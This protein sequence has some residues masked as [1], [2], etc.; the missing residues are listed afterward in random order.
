MKPP[1]ELSQM[2]LDVNSFTFSD[3]RSWRGACPNCGGHRRFVVFTDHEWPLFNGFC[4]ECG[5]KIKAWEKVKMQYDPQKAAALQAERAREEAERAEYRKVKL[6]EF[7]TA[8]LWA[9]L[10]DRMQ[11][12]HVLWWESQGIPEDIQRYLSIGYKADK[13]YYDG[14]HLERH[15]PAYTIPWFGLNFAFKTMQYRLCGEGIADRYRFE[16]GLDGGGKHYY[17]AD[18]AEPMKDRVIICEGAKKAIVTW[19]HLANITDFTVIAASSNNT[20][21]PALVATKDCGQRFI[22]LDPGSERRAF[23]VAK[24]HKVKAVYLPEKID[25]AVINDHLDRE[26]FQKILRTL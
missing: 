8:E 20:L 3:A 10:R 18:P 26:S 12:E 22:I 6:A 24:E 19:F 4:D 13:M 17:M 16:Y 15:S 2:G 7:T 11:T 25:D 5:L 21:G 9:E 23:T 1:L 14:E